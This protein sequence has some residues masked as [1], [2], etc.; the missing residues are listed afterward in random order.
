MEIWN[1]V[2]WSDDSKFTIFHSDGR[3]YVQE[4]AEGCV[5]GTVKHGGGRVMIWGCICGNETGMVLRVESTTDRF[6]YLQVLENGMIPSAWAM[7]GLD[8]IFMHDNAPC[9]W[10]VQHLNHCSIAEAWRKFS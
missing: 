4:F 9:H 7:R 2:V 5:V 3:T 8:Y 1:R 10:V 6:K